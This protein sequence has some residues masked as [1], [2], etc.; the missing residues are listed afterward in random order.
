MPVISRSGQVIG[1]L[2]F[3][4]PD[5]GVF[6]ERT[7]R[8]IGGVASQ[9][10]VAIDNAQLYEQVKLAAAEREK[11]LAAERSARAEAERVSLMKDEFLATLSHELRTPLNAILGWSQI[12]RTHA[13][14]DEEIDEGLSVIERNTRVQAQL[15]EDLLDMSRIVS[16]K[17]RLDVQQVELQEVVRSAVASVRLCADAKEIR[18]QQVLDP[19]A[20]PVRG[21]SRAAPAMLLEPAVQRD[22][23]HS[24]G[25]PVQ[26]TLQRVNSH[27]EIW[28]RTTGRASR[29]IFCRTCSSGSDRRTHRRRDG[30]AG[31]GWGCRS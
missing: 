6:N 13:H 30:M 26:V 3:G 24:Q 25:R 12:L 4:H 27:V 22:Q 5:K 17:I 20:G 29:R 2:F 23:V 14:R 31:W 9:A 28:S 8:I 1:G 18:I 19:L 11:P 7:E 16:G 15:I 10:A 21:R